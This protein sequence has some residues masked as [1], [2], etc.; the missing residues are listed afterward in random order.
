MREN[1]HIEEAPA[2]SAALPSDVKARWDV[3]A[4]A[5]RQ[6]ADA[7]DDEAGFQA[8]SNAMAQAARGLDHET[9]LNARCTSRRTPVSTPSP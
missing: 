7:T 2:G 5:A 8:A 1:D 4:D 9:L 3:L 6:L